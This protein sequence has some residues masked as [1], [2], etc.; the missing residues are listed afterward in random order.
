MTDDEKLLKIKQI[1][2]DARLAIPR[3]NKPDPSTEAIKKIRKLVM[4]KNIIPLDK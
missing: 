2:E 4:P 1:C 3:F